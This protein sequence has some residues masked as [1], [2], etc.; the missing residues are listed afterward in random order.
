MPYLVTLL[1][2]EHGPWAI[3]IAALLSNILFESTHKRTVERSL[4]Q[5]EQVFKLLTTEN[6]ATNFHRY[7]TN[8]QNNFIFIDAL[9]SFTIRLS[10]AYVTSMRPKWSVRCLLAD[11][12]VSLGLIKSALDLYLQIGKWQSIVECYNTL[13]LKHK[14]RLSTSLENNTNNNIRPEISFRKFFRRLM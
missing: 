5:C 2:Q 9:H 13:E 3:R 11:L 7:I 4:K 14:V 10:Y 8:T 12:M 6:S 1:E